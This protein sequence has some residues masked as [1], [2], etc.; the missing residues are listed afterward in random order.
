MNIYFAVSDSSQT[1]EKPDFITCLFEKIENKYIEKGTEITLKTNQYDFETVLISVIYSV[2]DNKKIYLNTLEKY[3]PML[4]YLQ[5]KF[6]F[7][8]TLITSFC[9]TGNLLGLKFIYNTLKLNDLSLSNNITYDDI[10]LLSKQGYIDCLK[11]VHK[12][13]CTW[14]LRTGFKA[15]KH[16]CYDCLKYLYNNGCP[17]V[18]ST[19]QYARLSNN[20]KCAIYCYGKYKKRSNFYA[21]ESL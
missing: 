15:A 16:G 13:N 9:K 12:R 1:Y 7:N 20:L 14:N 4:N 11:Y 18:R 3:L 5:C 2:I 19:F 17:I 8:E 10:N 21:V 6:Y